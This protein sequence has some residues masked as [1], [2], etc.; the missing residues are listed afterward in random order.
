MK[1]VTRSPTLT[2]DPESDVLR[3]RQ[4]RP[5]CRSKSDQSKTLPRPRPASSSSRLSSPKTPEEI[6]EDTCLYINTQLEK[7]IL[8]PPRKTATGNNYLLEAEV[9]GKSL[10][11]IGLTKKAT[12]DRLNDIHSTRKP[13]Q[14]SVKEPGLRRMA[15]VKTAEQL[16]LK[17]LGHFQHEFTC[18]ACQVEHGE[19]FCH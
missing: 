17:E 3:Q 2:Q 5:H 10:I 7:R 11:K 4:Y 6:A 19:Y 15:H 1:A 12:Y 16:T 13:T 18:K 14:L 9:D 8:T